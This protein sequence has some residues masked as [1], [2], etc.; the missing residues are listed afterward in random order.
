MPQGYHEDR[1]LENTELLERYAIVSLSDIRD[2]MAKLEA[3]HQRNNAEAADEQSQQR[4]SL[5][6][7]TQ[8]G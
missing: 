6:R 5:A 8:E 7:V 3:G 2:A 1:Q 4:S